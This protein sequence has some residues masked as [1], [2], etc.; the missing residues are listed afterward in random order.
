MCHG[1]GSKQ[2][3]LT[4]M[5]GLYGRLTTPLPSTI[6]YCKGTTLVVKNDAAGSFLANIVK[7]KSSCMN[8]GA[9]QMVA[10]MPDDCSTTSSSPRRC[11]T[12]EQA[13]IISNWIAAGAPM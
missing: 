12:T 7:A 9:M 11:L 6:P 10:R 3:N 8:D 1:A 5:A 4:D 2:V 13:A